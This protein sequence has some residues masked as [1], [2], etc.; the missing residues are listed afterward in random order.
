MQRNVQKEKTLYNQYTAMTNNHLVPIEI[1]KQVIMVGVKRDT[2][3]GMAA[4]INSYYQYIDKLQYITSWK[5]ASMPVKVWYAFSSIVQFTLS[6][7]FNKNIKIVH[8]QGAA[9]A[10]FSRK[11]VFVKIAKLFGKKV[12]MHQHACDFVEYYDNHKN[13]TWITQTINNCDTLIVLSQWWKEYFTSIGIAADKIVILNNI[14]T[15]PPTHKARK[16]D[17]KIRLLFLGE[18]GKRKGI[19]DLLTAISNKREYFAQHIELHIGGNLEE[20]KL[21]T[22]IHDHNLESFVTFMGWVSGEKKR[23]CLE[24]AHIYILPSYNEGLPIGILEAMSYRMPIISTPVGGI[25]EV[26]KNYHNGILVQ[27][28]NHDEISNALLY[29]IE[30]PQHISQYGEVSYVMAQPYFPE[31]VMGSLCKVYSDLL[32]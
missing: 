19:Y 2:P 3:G 9:N 22:F 30:N 6:L 31:S 1:S 32:K 20:D 23:E 21:R 4:V 17:G 27:P 10:S 29:F 15:P 26:V 8:I 5:L 16:I 24:W 28:G 7:I 25:P 12:I 11:A 13:K 14:V 18:I